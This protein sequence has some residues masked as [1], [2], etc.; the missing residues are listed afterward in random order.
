VEGLAAKAGISPDMVQQFLPHVM[1]LLQGHAEN[2]SDGVQGMLGGLMGSVGGL[3]GGAGGAG[4]V[5]ESAGASS[6]LVGLVKG[7]FGSKE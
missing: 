4:D 1:P 2:A 5:A 3:L 6:G 7:L